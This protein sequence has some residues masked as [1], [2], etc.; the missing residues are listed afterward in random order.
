M[1]R[2]PAQFYES[3]LIRALNGARKAGFEAGEVRI[4][5]VTGEIILTAREQ[6]TPASGNSVD[7]I[8]EATRA[9]R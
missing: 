2:R 6:V 4:D 8:L 9:K 5:P 1:A 7:S 3:D